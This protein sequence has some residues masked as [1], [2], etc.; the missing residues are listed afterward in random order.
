MS[1]T[2]KRPEKKSPTPPGRDVAEK[3]DPSQTEG[4]FLQDLSRATSNKAKKRLA[5]PARRG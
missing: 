1:P 3:Q 5:A 2:R 4:D